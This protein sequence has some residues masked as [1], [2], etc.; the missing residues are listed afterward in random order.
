MSAAASGRILIVDDEKA[1]RDVLSRLLRREGYEYLEAVNGERA[2]ALVCSEPLDAVLL[3]IRMPGLDG[4]EVL[5]QIKLLDRELPVVMVTADGLVQQAV[6]AMRMGAHDYLVKPFENVAVIRSISRA[7]TATGC[8]EP[9]KACLSKR[10]QGACLRDTMGS[11]EAMVTLSAEVA[12][13]ACSDLT[14]LILG[15]TG[16]GKEL[17]SLAIHAVSPRASALFVAVDCGAI[18]E[19]LFESELF[20]HEKGAFTGSDRSEERRVGKECRL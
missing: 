7:L 20:G 18:P 8:A 10:Q 17:V 5:R 4:L 6:T 2:L 12:R 11:S 3:D 19:T 9:R 14:V 13:V 16:T 15:E 1:V